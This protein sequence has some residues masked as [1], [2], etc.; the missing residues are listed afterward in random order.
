LSETLKPDKGNDIQ[1]FAL[2]FLEAIPAAELKEVSGRYND[3]LQVWEHGEGELS[4]AFP[5]ASFPAVERPATIS[6]IPT[7]IGP[8]IVRSD[9]GPDD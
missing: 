4:T 3:K 5:V 8:K 6:T 2:Q 9:Q 7:R 1:P